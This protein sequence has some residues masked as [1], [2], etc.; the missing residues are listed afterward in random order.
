MK[1][2]L[3]ILFISTIYAKES[4][5]NS[6]TYIYTFN[7]L[8]NIVKSDKLQKLPQYEVSINNLYKNNLDI[9]TTDAKRTLS[10]SSDI[11]KSFRKKAHPNG[12]CFKG[13]WN[14]DTANIYS[15]YFQNN[16]RSNIIVRASSA[17]SN[18]KSNETRIL[19]FAGKIFPLDKD[20]KHK[21]A[22]FFLIDD[23]GG[24]NKK[25]YSN[26]TLVNEPPLSFTHVIL[27]NLLYS[28]KIA[29]TF[30]DADKN[31]KIR[32][33]YQV[34][35]YLENKAQNTITPKWMKLTMKEKHKGNMKDGIDFRDELKIINNKFLVFNIFVANK[36]IKEKKNW[37]KIG[38]IT[39]E[40]SVVSNSCDSRLH[41][42][43]PVFI[44]GLN[45]GK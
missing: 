15:G 44:D 8:W 37:K 27:K 18:T 20:I 11:L 34:S 7:E 45:Y 24:T 22:N 33:L 19:G 32:Q 36:K 4:N 2:L 30:E 3:V 40:E 28:I 6:Q 39:L 23:L 26:I 13:I 10:N 9:I 35:Q 38:T 1:T 14:I 12:I 17:M 42:W 25:Y 21:S 31:S 43:H 41:F 16:T 5:N 29:N